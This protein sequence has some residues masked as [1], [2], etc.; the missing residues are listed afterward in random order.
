MR[1]RKVTM[2]QLE[3]VLP[4]IEET[5]APSST[6][7]PQAGSF[8]AHEFVKQNLPIK[9]EGRWNNATKYILE[10][11]PFNP[12]HKGSE[13]AIL[14]FDN[15]GWDFV[16]QHNS[17]DH[18]THEDVRLIFEPN[19]YAW[20][21]KSSQHVH[22]DVNGKASAAQS[23]AAAAPAKMKPVQKREIQP[24]KKFPL[25][26]LPEPLRSFARETAAA[27]G[28]D[29]AFM[30]LPSIVMAAA[31]IGNTHR[32]RLKHG[33]NEPPILWG[34]IIGDSGTGKSPALRAATAPIKRVQSNYV[35]EHEAALEAF[36]FEHTAWQSQ[37]EAWKRDKGI[38]GD[39]PIEPKP[40]AMKRIWLADSTIEALVERLQTSPRGLVVI[41]DE[42][43]GWLGG[44]NQYK[45]KGRGNDTAH[46]LSMFNGDEV[47]W[48]RRT[49]PSTFINVKSAAVCVVGGIQPGILT[50]SL[51][52]EHWD[53]GLAPR[54]LMVCPPKRQRMWTEDTIS[55]ETEQRVEELFAELLALDFETADDGSPRPIVVPLGR[56]AKSL[57]IDYYNQHAAEQSEM[58]SR[59]SSLWSKLEAY[60]PRFALVHHLVRVAAGERTVNRTAIDA[61]SMEAGIGLADWFGHEARRI[62]GMFGESADDRES[63]EL[64]EFILTK[65][66]GS[67][68]A[69]ELMRAKR[70]YRDSAEAAE[71]ALNELAKNGLG[72]WENQPHNR[73]GRPGRLLVCGDT[74]SENPEEKRIVSPSPPKEEEKQGGYTSRNIDNSEK[75]LLETVD[76]SH[77]LS[78][79]GD[80]IERNPKKTGIVSP[81][82]SQKRRHSGLDAWP[83][84]TQLDAPASD[85]SQTI[86]E[87]SSSDPPQIIGE[88]STAKPNQLIDEVSSRQKGAI[89]CS[90]PEVP[91]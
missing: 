72:K 49:G 48:D 56:E 34:A 21:N 38:R 87:G 5:P 58:N 91:Q 75:M 17:C 74:I 43:A 61:H 85:P 51:T 10:Q 82:P 46:W 71:Q 14:V 22:H 36:Q 70:R 37:A 19:A 55:E 83:G 28:M 31:T 33:W 20:R 30:A 40:P 24:Y 13:V 7:T 66:G 67:I 86:D 39:P 81:L 53:N 4:A 64:V 11:C 45:G 65:F 16:C 84:G 35:K 29:P 69:R 78:G 80:T 89:N 12:D 8:N 47:V 15:G 1:K 41:A 25:E 60:A 50:R 76:N 52:D 2:E 9:S 42:L 18:K 63:R 68:T 77:S 57:F 6:Y 27:I 88:G 90:F 54:L 44:H 59:E 23:S 3:E 62:Y 32:I 79:D 26:Y 73:A